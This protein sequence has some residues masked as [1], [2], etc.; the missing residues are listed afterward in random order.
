MGKRIRGL[1]VVLKIGCVLE[2][3]IEAILA[4][5]TGTA[6]WSSL[7]SASVLLTA[8]GSEF[9]GGLNTEGAGVVHAVCEPLNPSAGKSA[10]GAGWQA[11]W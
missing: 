9:A 8:T 3:P 5:P 6:I 2:L 4:R 1:I 11:A 7:G 10:I